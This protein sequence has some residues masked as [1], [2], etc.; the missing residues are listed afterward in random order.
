[1]EWFLR[2][3]RSAGSFPWASLAR[4]LGVCLLCFGLLGAALGG[5]YRASIPEV[6]AITEIEGAASHAPEPGESLPPQDAEWQ[7]YALPL[8]ICKVRCDTLYTVYRHR[9]DLAQ[10]ARADWALYLPFFDANVAV[11]LNGQM[12]DQQGRMLAP[13][14]VY[15]FHSR[16]VRL[17]QSRLR[18][19]ENELLLQ[20][21]AERPYYGAL[22]PM[23]L[24]PMEALAAPQRWRA[25]LTEHTIAGVGWLHAGSLL[26]AL[27]LFLGGRRESVLGWYLVA[28][29]FWLALIALHASPGLLAAT[30]WRW[31]ATFLSVAGVLS[32]SPLFILS[33]L[34]PPPTWM[35][36]A[37]LGLFGI[38]LVTTVLAMHVL[39]L[40]A[41]WQFQ[42]PNYTLKL[43][44]LLLV[45]LMLGLVLRIV[46][47]R[48]SSWSAAWLLALAAMPG[49]FGIA[50]AVMGSISPPLQMA[51]LPL[52][53]LGVSMAL[54]LEL[55]RRLIENH[56]RLASHAAE[57]EQTVRAREADLRESYERLRHADRERALGEERQRLLHD[58]HDGVGG[59]LA[60][61]VHLAGNPEIGRDQVVA[62]LR[63]GLADLRL[64]LDSLAQGED[65]P[66]VALGRLRHRIQPPL[67]AAGINLHWAVDPKLELP[68]WSPEAVLHI[69]RLLQESIHNVIRHAQ[70]RNLTLEVRGDGDRIEFGVIDDGVGMAPGAAAGP[71]YGLDS[72]RAR[73]IKLGGY[74]TLTPAPGGGTEVRVSLPRVPMAAAPHE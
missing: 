49:V 45:P 60:S 33:I 73:A 11:Y 31:T 20:L 40:D 3:R 58:M 10:S 62:G 37:L 7:R 66:M 36:R 23:Y 24:A 15:R 32:F 48:K 18:L 19:G 41:Y 67:E 38:C 57:L 4:A 70:A 6:P 13:A 29:V 71:G 16:L 54:W 39:D 68:A 72:L 50:D 21:V 27:A 17:P 34:Q 2:L 1:M 25:R 46:L 8:R 42:V 53:G 63:E 5:M 28:A 14:D 64:V 43:S 22:S 30:P 74:L 35:V 51:L 56:R 12:L 47:K 61:L 69:Y 65:D 55:I 26:V 52:G 44:A 59:Q 9:F